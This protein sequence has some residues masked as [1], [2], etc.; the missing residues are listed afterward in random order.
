MV[1]LLKIH[2]TFHYRKQIQ[3]ILSS[4]LRILSITD[5]QKPGN[6]K[7]FRKVFKNQ[8]NLEPNSQERDSRF[9]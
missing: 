6:A 9:P 4:S 8:K 7:L 2:V 5:L 3:N 1:P